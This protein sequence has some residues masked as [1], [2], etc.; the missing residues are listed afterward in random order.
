M[1]DVGEPAF[2]PTKRPAYEPAERLLRPTGYQPDMPRP[3]TTV[4]GAVLVML[5]VVAGVLVLIAVASGWDA[6][7]D[8]LELGADGAQLTPEIQ[9]VTL[10]LVLVGGSILLLA[11]LLLALFTLRGHNTP[12]VIVM[13][14]SVFSISTTFTAWWEQG[15]D[16]TL[17][18]T[19]LSLSLDILI[20]LALSSRSAAAYA[21]RRERG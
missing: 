10:V 2:P 5:R 17:E 6:L 7:A 20:L 14:I 15:Q 3:I 4:V 8:D 9:H 11:D 13:L 18:G 16:I 1:T 19:F 21:R 12:R